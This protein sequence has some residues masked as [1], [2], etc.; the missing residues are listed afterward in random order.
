MVR[1][2]FLIGSPVSAD[3]RFVQLAEANQLLVRIG[4]SLSIYKTRIRNDLFWN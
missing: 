2:K 1:F 4:S 3:L